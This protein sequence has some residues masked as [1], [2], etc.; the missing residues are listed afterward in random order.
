MDDFLEATVLYPNNPKTLVTVCL[1]D[2]RREGLVHASQCNRTT[3]GG[4]QRCV[5]PRGAGAALTTLW[6]EREA[7]AFCAYPIP[8]IVLHVTVQCPLVAVCK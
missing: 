6:V 7:C 5:P 1:W 2:S 4:L 8:Q 3:I